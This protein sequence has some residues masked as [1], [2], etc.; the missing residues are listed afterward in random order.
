MEKKKILVL[1]DDMPWGHRSIAKAIYEFLK[2]NE[3]KENYKVEYAQVKSKLNFANN[4]YTFFYRYLPKLWKISDSLTKTRLVRR[5]Y[6]KVF[7][8]NLL[9]IKKVVLKSNP[10]LII[11]AFFGHSQAL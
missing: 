3:E 6:R 10:D 8:C 1:T 7:D 9:N 4:L 5:I 2:K 11:S